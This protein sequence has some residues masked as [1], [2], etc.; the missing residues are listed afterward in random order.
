[1]KRH[2][3]ILLGAVF[4]LAFLSLMPDKSTSQG[5]HV[6]YMAA[7][8]DLAA[9]LR[10]LRAEIQTADP[11]DTQRLSHISV[12]IYS[13]RLRIKQVDFWLRYL[14]AGAYRLINS[15]LPVEWET[16]VFEKFEKPYKRMGRGLT[17]AALLCDKD[18]V[19]KPALLSV[20][21]SAIKGCT[22]FRSDSVIARMS[23]HHHFYLCNRLFLLNL[24]AIYTTGFDCPS[25]AHVIPELRTMLHAVN[26][27]YEA[28]NKDFPG[29]ALPAEY[30]QH[31]Q[32]LVAFTDRQPSDLA[33]FDHYTFIRDHVNP[34]FGINQQLILRYNISSR[35]L[36]DYS[37]GRGSSSIFDKRLYNGQN[38]KGIFRR[39]SDSAMLVK[40]RET[41]KLL[42]YD[43]ILSGNNQRSCAS[44]H[45]PAELFTDTTVRTA[46]HFDK[47]HR[48]ARNTP[49]L[50]NAGFNHL[51]MA[52]GRHFTLE[53]QAKDVMTNP[54]EMGCEATEIVGKVLTCKRYRRAFKKL[55]TL[56]PQEK[57]V[58]VEHIASCITWYYSTFS[59]GYS[60]FDSAMNAQTRLAASEKRG[61]NLFM[62]KAQ[63]ATCHFVPQFNG[64]KPP[65]IG[66][67]FEV[68]G[69]PA[70]NRYTNLSTDSGRYLVNPA[71]ETMRA[72]RTGTVRNVSRTAP[73]MHNGAFK[74]LG[75][76]IDFYDAGG[77]A[78]HGLDPG[79]QTLSADSLHLSPKEKEDLIAF[80]HSLNE[81]VPAAEV[82]AALPFSRSKELNKRKPSG[83]Y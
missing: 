40:I 51:L 19:E 21:D 78:G 64:V 12:S 71:V 11:E 77:G 30:L 32:D 63:C 7:T 42:F 36:L 24:A 43:P 2:L 46:L 33:Q 15:P 17:L 22:I 3:L 47:T 65:Y 27:I 61:F 58:T 23:D 81:A 70:D 79:N 80:I 25:P 76:V 67:E 66:S 4:L 56:T 1:M 83:N 74:T 45:K 44:C 37:L 69:V 60:R 49:S 20:V 6:A 10:R 75:E 50:V 31:Y 38:G 28:F 13:A 59:N 57:A 72:F 35:S 26:G 5:Y 29:T 52:D 9:E 18:R 54:S 53:N 41:G 55:L 48:L 62:G 73:Y 14:D 8:A 16:E 34:L 68:L 39:V 82:P